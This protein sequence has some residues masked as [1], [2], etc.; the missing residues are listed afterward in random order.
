MR[1][2][3]REMFVKL[4]TDTKK[5]RNIVIIFCIG[6]VFRFG[7]STL[8]AF[9]GKLNKQGIQFATQNVTYFA[10]AQLVS[11]SLTELWPVGYLLS[12]H[13]RN[14]RPDINDSVSCLE[15]H[16]TRTVMEYSDDM[17]V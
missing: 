14:F 4:S 11:W 2:V 8:F 10:L 13:Y 5:I 9:W 1:Q 6:F 15:N 12:V 17:S 3:K 16:L 7:V